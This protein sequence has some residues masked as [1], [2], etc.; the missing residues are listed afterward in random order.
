MNSKLETLEKVNQKLAKPVYLLGLA[1]LVVAMPMVGYM[2]GW[3]ITD[4][5]QKL[6]QQP[7]LIFLPNADLFVEEVWA[8]ELSEGFKYK[9]TISDNVGTKDNIG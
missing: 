5:N 9:V 2:F 8:E 1:T 7:Q 6:A 3:A 4:Y